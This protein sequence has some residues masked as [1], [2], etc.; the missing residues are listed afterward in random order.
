MHGAHQRQ[1][2]VRRASRTIV[3]VL[4]PIL[5]GIGACVSNGSLAASAGVAA[6]PGEDP[7]NGLRWIRMASEGDQ[8]HSA[9]WS[10]AVGPP[11]AE[12][13][14]RPAAA[15]DG[16]AVAIVSWNTH[17]G[18]GD[19]QALVDDLRNGRL[20]GGRHVR[21]FV[22]LL[23]EVYRR[24]SNVPETLPAGS[25]PAGFMRHA[26]PGVDRDIVV[27]ARGLGLDVL[28][29][30]SMRN[31]GQVQEDRG[32]AI[33]STLPLE[34]DTAIELPFEGQRRVAVAATV[35]LPGVDGG[36]PAIRVASLHLTNMV[37][38]H[39]WLLSEPAPVRQARAFARTIGGDPIVV[40]GD[41]NAWFGSV[42]GAYRELARR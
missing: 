12:T 2:S 13:R 33:L 39:G 6:R 10:A 29:V 30:P 20:T 37:G 16:E 24:A 36:R 41:L 11:V 18:G 3:G 8:R 14:S 42:D 5:S 4:L 35:R 21:S 32:N 31:G 38:H 40:G 26:P 23:Q 27:T 17:V 22:L 9:R 25:R 15:T 7:S 28:Y 19:V 1:W 34:D